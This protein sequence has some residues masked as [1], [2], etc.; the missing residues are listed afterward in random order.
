MR[1]NLVNFDYCESC[2]RRSER[3]IIVYLNIM[4]GNN[5]GTTICSFICTE[6]IALDEVELN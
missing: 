5:S 3:L 1:Y 4:M 2:T 6:H